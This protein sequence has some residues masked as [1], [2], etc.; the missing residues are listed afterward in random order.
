MTDRNGLATTYPIELPDQVVSP[1]P[2]RGGVTALAEDVQQ[3]DRGIRAEVVGY[4]F[5][6]GDEKGRRLDF[7]RFVRLFRLARHV[8]GPSS[9]L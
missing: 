5:Q 3:P 7:V 6:N 9:L 8:R 1:A 2:A 4:E